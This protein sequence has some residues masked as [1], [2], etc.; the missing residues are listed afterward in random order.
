MNTSL[1]TLALFTTLFSASNA[2][3][4]WSANLVVQL[5]KEGG[6][7][8][9]ACSDN[10]I[11]MLEMEMKEWLNDD[12]AASFGA[13]NF[14]LS[15]VHASDKLDHIDMFAQFHCVSSPKSLKSLVSPL[16]WVTQALVNHWVAENANLLDGCMGLDTVVDLSIK[17]QPAAVV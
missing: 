11:S 14:I 9:S 16:Q 15:D 13:K 2:S 7:P 6:T 8:P 3:S 17:K 12:L 4:G 1:L 10:V 5:Q